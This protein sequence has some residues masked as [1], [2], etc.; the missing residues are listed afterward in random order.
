MIFHAALALVFIYCGYDKA[1][2]SRSIQCVV[3]NVSAAFR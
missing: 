3:I 1:N 2:S